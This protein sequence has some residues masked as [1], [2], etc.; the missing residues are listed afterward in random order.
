MRTEIRFAGIGGQGSVLASSILAEAAGM[1]GS[2]AVQT[3]FY[4]AAIRG[5]AA[6]GDTV[7][8]DEPISFPWVLNPDYLVAQHQG[9]VRAH[10]DLVKPDGV[11]IADLMYVTEIPETTATVYHVP[12]TEIA[13]GVGIRRVANMVALAVLAKVSGVIEYEQ[14]EHAVLA[15]SP[16]GSGPTNQLALRQGFDLD[17][18]QHRV[19]TTAGVSA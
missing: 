6:A 14:L 1:A 10:F 15:K 13:D 12:L 3:Q 2:E 8:G 9:A 16:F 18:E 19:A 11:V 5:G 4:E 17:L 7:I